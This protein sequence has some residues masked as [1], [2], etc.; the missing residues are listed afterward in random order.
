[1]LETGQ[2]EPIAF[3]QSDFP[4]KFGIPRQSG[5][6][7]QLQARVV[8][9]PKY[10]QEEALRGIEGFSHLWL[11]WEFSKAKRS[12]WSATVRP[13]RL[14]GNQRMG[15]FATRSPF[16]PNPIGLSCVR[17]VAVDLHTPQGPILH[18]AGADLMDGTPILD[19]KPYVPYA[20]CKPM[21]TAGFAPPPDRAALAVDI[22]RD[23]LQRIPEGKWEALKGVLAQDPRP[24]YQDDPERV[25]G[26]AFAGMEIRFQ[27]E[28]ERLTVLAVEKP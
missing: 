14:G 3:I 23:L 26:M 27:V 22:S 5:L 12:E 18:V 11:I 15:V 6:V 4:T 17:L 24:S 28:G 21:A 1:M 2:M 13:P 20:D 8:F 25:Y 16:R 7:E 19:I 10:R 9:A